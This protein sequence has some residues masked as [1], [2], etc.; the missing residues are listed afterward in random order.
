MILSIDGYTEKVNFG[1]EVSVSEKKVLSLNCEGSDMS[2][3]LQANQL[4]C[5][6]LDGWMV[7]I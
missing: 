5:H 3:H 6:S 2:C 7:D 4:G 1:D